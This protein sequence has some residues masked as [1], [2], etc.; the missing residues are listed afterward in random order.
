M[1]ELYLHSLICLHGIV[2]KLS[3][4]TLL[5]FL[6]TAIRKELHLLQVGVVVW[7]NCYG[8]LFPIAFKIMPGSLTPR[9]YTPHL[10]CAYIY[11]CVCV[12]VSHCSNDLHF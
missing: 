10:R 12:C 4:G 6:N 2:L 3:T 7:I 9:L 1:V 5:L 11:M 8:I